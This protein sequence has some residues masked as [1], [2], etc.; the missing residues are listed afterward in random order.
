MAGHTESKSGEG[1]SLKAR[2][3]A[4]AVNIVGGTTEIELL[5]M[6]GANLASILSGKG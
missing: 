3:R 5:Q 4:G 2:E 6:Q 1:Q